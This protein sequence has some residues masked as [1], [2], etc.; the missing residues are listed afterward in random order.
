MW[1]RCELRGW[2][3]WRRCGTSRVG[4]R[5]DEK[6]KRKEREKRKDNAEAQSTQRRAEKKKQ[7]PRCARN[8]YL[9][10]TAP[11]GEV[12]G[13]VRCGAVRCGEHGGRG[14]PLPYR[15]VGSRPDARRWWG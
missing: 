3:R 1:R 12:R 9:C 11:D 13:R 7:I 2:I 15:W 8:D 4:E 5:E 14:E 6:K 10:G